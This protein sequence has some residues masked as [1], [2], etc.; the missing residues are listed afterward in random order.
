MM[1][2]TLEARVSLSPDSP[3]EMSTRE[4]IP[5]AINSFFV[6]SLP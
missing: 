3:T 4:E 5:S 6:D 1:Q 2:L